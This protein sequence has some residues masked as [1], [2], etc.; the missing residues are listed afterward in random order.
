MVLDIKQNQQSSNILLD[1]SEDKINTILLALDSNY[2]PKYFKHVIVEDEVQKF[3]GIT[4]ENKTLSESILS[5]IKHQ[6]ALLDHFLPLI[7]GKLA[8][9]EIIDEII[10]EPEIVEEP[11]FEQIV[12]EQPIIEDTLVV[13]K[14]KGGFQ[15]GHQISNGLKKKE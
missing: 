8:I 4:Y 10:P 11:E 1:I 5:K 12:E 2:D 7:E 14:K 9:K 13:G 15:K 6:H 3:E